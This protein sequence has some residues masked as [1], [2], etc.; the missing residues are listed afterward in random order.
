MYW[1]ANAPIAK[2]AVRIICYIIYI[3]YWTVTE[4]CVDTNGFIPNNQT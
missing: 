1:D 2:N 4:D 3:F